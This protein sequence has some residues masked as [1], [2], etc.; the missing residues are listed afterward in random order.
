MALAASALSDVDEKL[1]LILGLALRPVVADP[2]DEEILIP[3]EED[4]FTF[5]AT[6]AVNCCCSCS[7]DDNAN[8]ADG[9]DDAEDDDDDKGANFPF[10]DDSPDAASELVRAST[11]NLPDPAADAADATDTAPEGSG[12]GDIDIDDSEEDAAAFCV[13]SPN[14]RRCCCSIDGRGWIY[15]CDC[16]CK[17][18]CL[19]GCCCG[20]LKVICCGCMRCWCC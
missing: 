12:G 11:S 2:D 13:L 5:A 3:T 1:P 20:C 8:E 6:L 15:D 10:N 7:C 14:A 4:P 16:A 9:I 19:D 17:R 18:P